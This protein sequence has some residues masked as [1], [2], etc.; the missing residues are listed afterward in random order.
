MKRMKLA[1]KQMML[2]KDNKKSKLTIVKVMSLIIK[3]KIHYN[4][5]KKKHLLKKLPSMNQ[6]LL[7]KSNKQF[8]IA[9]KK[10]LIY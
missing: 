4:H 1:E 10:M 2:L 7:L 9:K 5:M 3:E 8:W 6:N